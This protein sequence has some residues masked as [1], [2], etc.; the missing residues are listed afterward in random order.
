MAVFKWILATFAIWKDSQGHADNQIIEEVVL[1]ETL[2]NLGGDTFYNCFNL[3]KVNI[4]KNVKIMGNNP[5]AGCP[6][7]ELVN[8]SSYFNY[9]NGVLY[10]KE[11]TNVNNM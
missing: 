11:K 5:F 9:V 1:P 7:L 10:N 3:K 8:E 2:V 4:P 6:N